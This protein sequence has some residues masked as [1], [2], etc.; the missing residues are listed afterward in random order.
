MAELPS[1]SKENSIQSELLTKLNQAELESAIDKKID[2][3]HGLL[4]KDAAMRMLAI[5][6]GLIKKQENTGDYIKINQIK[7]ETRNINLKAKISRIFDIVISSSGKK[8]RDVQISDETGNAKLRFWEEDISFL[9]KIKVGDEIQLNNVYEKMGNLNIGYEGEIKILN[10]APFDTLNNLKDGSLV[11]LKVTVS[12]IIGKEGIIKNGKN[13]FI[14]SFEV[15]D[16]TGQKTVV[17]WEAIERAI[18]FQENDQLII[19]GVLFLDNLI[20]VY[21]STRLLHK[22]YSTI[23]GVLKDAIVLSENGAEFLKIFILDRSLKLDRT[24]ALKFLDNNIAD[25]ILLQTIVQIKKEHLL[26]NTIAIKGK[27]VGGLFVLD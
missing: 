6:Y 4:T 16:E 27:E 8:Y 11:N 22:P 24:N 13:I 7:P 3:F 15:T 21:S 18:K 5:D 26:N 23:S 20:N 17:I 1:S 19:Q 2:E 9:S 12:K 14:F 25:D 10:K